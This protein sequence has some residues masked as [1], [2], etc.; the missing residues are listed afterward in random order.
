MPLETLLT[1]RQV[2]VAGTW[3]GTRRFIVPCSVDEVTVGE[4]HAAAADLPHGL[5]EGCQLPLETR[6][7]HEGDFVPRV[8]LGIDEEHMLAANLHDVVLWTYREGRLEP[9]ATW[10]VPGKPWSISLGASRD[11]SL[12]VAGGGDAIVHLGTTGDGAVHV[13]EDGKISRVA[14]AADGSA[15]AAGLVDGRVQF[16]HPA[17]LAVERSVQISTA[18]ILCL[19]FDPQG[20]YLAV[21]DDLGKVRV[22]DVST[23]EVSYTPGGW[24]K[25]IGLHWLP[26]GRLAIVRL[27]RMISIHRGEE[28]VWERSFPELGKCYIQRSAMVGDAEGLVLACESRGLCYVPLPR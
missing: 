8:L 11:G 10:A 7:T 15:V 22:V 16:R 20:R 26:G 25:A 23:G 6:D 19:A 1:D 5:G 17:T 21:A 27:S 28:T 9:E 4:V 18:A 12:M 13:I 14:V 3:P 24:S 2:V